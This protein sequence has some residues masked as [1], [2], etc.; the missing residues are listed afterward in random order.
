MES[1]CT[2][3]RIV[4]V[5]ELSDL[6]LNCLKYFDLLILGCLQMN[7]SRDVVEPPSMNGSMNL[8]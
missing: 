3:K 6:S 4:A 5:N 7:H 1:D 2:M 8:E